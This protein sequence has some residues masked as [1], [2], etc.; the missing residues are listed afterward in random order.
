M[1]VIV[2]VVKMLFSDV[3]SGKIGLGLQ[4]MTSRFVVLDALLLSY[5]RLE[6][7]HALVL[8][9]VVPGSYGEVRNSRK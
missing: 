5:E 1:I 4:A 8:L 2:I 3:V 7:I 9:F 6:F